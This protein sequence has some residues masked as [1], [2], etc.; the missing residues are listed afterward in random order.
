MIPVYNIY[1][2][3]TILCKHKLHILEILDCGTKRR[4]KNG[5]ASLCHYQRNEF[6]IFEFVAACGPRQTHF[7]TEAQT[8]SRD[9]RN[10]LRQNLTVLPDSP[11]CRCA[12]SSPGRGKS[13]LSGGAL[14]VLTGRWQKAPPLGEA[15]IEQSEMTERVSHPRAGT[16]L[17][18]RVKLQKLISVKR[19]HFKLFFCPKWSIMRP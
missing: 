1:I 9:W 4:L 16:A 19:S 13:F 2:V 17:L 14:S 15:G 12:T 3:K 6:Y 7:H 18:I 8:D 5:S 10:P 11:F